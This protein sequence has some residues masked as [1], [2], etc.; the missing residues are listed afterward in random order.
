[1]GTHYLRVAGI[2]RSGNHAV[3]NWILGHYP[4]TFYLHNCSL[5]VNATQLIR[6]TSNRLHLADTHPE[7]IPVGKDS[8]KGL[9]I[10]SYEDNDPDKVFRPGREVHYKEYFGADSYNHVLILRD[11]YNMTASRLYR[12]YLP[13]H[14]VRYRI[15]DGKHEALAEL[16]KMYARLFLEKENDP[17]WL[18]VCFNRWFKDIN[19]R[20][21]LSAKINKPFTDVGYRGSTW[22]PGKTSFEHG[23]ECTEN[24]KIEDRWRNY[25]AHSGYR[26]FIEDEEMEELSRQITG[27]VIPDKTPVSPLKSARL[28][29]RM[30]PRDFRTLVRL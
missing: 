13:N 30:K 7:Y 29:R 15:L 18:C 16:W 10:V 20:K 22:R 1:M 11:P 12:E 5:Q 2:K 23:Y 27:F 26:K 3:M 28:P 14:W 4:G 24:Y 21:K 8:E 25:I 17:N 6:P 19:Y 9:A